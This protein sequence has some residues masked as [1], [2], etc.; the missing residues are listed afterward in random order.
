MLWVFWRRRLV[1]R[2]DFVIM[3]LVK[4]GMILCYCFTSKVGLGRAGY[5]LYRYLAYRVRLENTRPVGG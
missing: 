1:L 3:V 4:L 5:R 2:G